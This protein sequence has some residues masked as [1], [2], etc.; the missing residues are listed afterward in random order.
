VN[1]ATHQNG[2]KQVGNRIT[3]YNP[4]TRSC[5]TSCHGNETW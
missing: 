1:A 3:S 2:T 4:T 5:A